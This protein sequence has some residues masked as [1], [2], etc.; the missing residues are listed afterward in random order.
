MSEDNYATLLPH[1]YAA[2]RAAAALVPP[3]RV[4]V[5]FDHATLLPAE[6]VTLTLRNVD[7]LIHA[8]EI[9]IVQLVPGTESLPLVDAALGM[10]EPSAGVVRVNG[11]DWTSLL[12]E[13]Q[14]IWRGRAGRVFNGEAWISNLT[15]A[16]NVVLSRSHHTHDSIDLIAADTKRWAQRF[17]LEAVPAERPSLVPASIRRLCE[18]VRAFFHEPALLLLEN[19]TRGAP[20]EATEKLLS[21]LV[22]AQGR[23]AAILLL[24]TDDE[25]WSASSLQDATRFVIRDD[26]L[27][28]CEV[29]P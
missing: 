7:L 24:T 12:P 23:G 3:R 10:L 13:E 21:A 14:L 11:R 1:A 16:D 28:P 25:L 29:L 4:V 2:A 18:W 15:L 8:G 26:R 20:R 22:E 6:R 19:P 27:L 17:G 9:V 5:E